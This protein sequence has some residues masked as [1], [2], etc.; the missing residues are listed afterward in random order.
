[1]LLRLIDYLKSIKVTALMTAV[2]TGNVHD[3]EQV[4]V[5]S[6]MDAWLQVQMIEGCGERNRGLYVIKARGI[7]HSNQIR[8]FLLSDQGISLRDAY[9]GEGA[10]LTGSARLAQEAREMEQQAERQAAVAARRREITRKRSQIEAQ[11]AILQAELEEPS[12]EEETFD[13][14]NATP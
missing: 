12:G 5:S 7:A 13:S 14:R 2:D 6:L 10:V 4:G 3:V 8:E 1:M 9:L 11:I